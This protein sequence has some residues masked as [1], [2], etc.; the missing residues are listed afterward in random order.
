MHP[1]VSVNEDGISIRW[2]DTAIVTI[3]SEGLGYAIGDGKHFFAGS[4]EITDEASFTA[5]MRELGSAVNA[6]KS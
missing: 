5:A 3:T 4:H 1:N 6:K 2:G